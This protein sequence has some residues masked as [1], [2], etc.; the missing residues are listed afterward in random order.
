MPSHSMELSHG[1][2]LLTGE[3]LKVSSETLVVRRGE[4]VCSRDKRRKPI[5]IFLGQFPIF[6]AKCSQHEYS[7]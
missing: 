5:A 1:F 3:K 7:H 6:S 2:R 4:A